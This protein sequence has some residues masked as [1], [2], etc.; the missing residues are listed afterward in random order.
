LKSTGGSAPAWT[1]LSTADLSGTISLTSQVTGVL[2]SANGGTGVDN[3]G[4]TITLGGNL[5][6]QGAITTLSGSNT[7]DNAVNSL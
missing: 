4:K 1:T 2:P 5:T 7:G 6:T 3:T